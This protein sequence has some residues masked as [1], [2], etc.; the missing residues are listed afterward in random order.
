MPSKNKRTEGKNQNPNTCF[1]CGSKDQWITD[2]P[3]PENSE[4]RV[5]CKAENTKNC[6]YRSTKIDIES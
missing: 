6:A 4:N 2:C 3:N 5:Y 1:K